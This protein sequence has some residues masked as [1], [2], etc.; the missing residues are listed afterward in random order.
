M[1]YRATV[2]SPRPTYGLGTMPG[3]TDP[4]SLYSTSY[5]RSGS[6]SRKYDSSSYLSSSSRPSSISRPLPPG[7]GPL[8]TSGRRF[9]TDSRRTS[10]SSL[11][12]GPLKADHGYTP[13]IGTLPRKYTNSVYAGS[14]TTSDI[15]SRSVRSRSVANFD[16]VTNDVSNLKLNDYDGHSI[17]ASPRTIDSD[18]NILGNRESRRE[19]HENSLDW[20]SGSR[21]SRYSNSSLNNDDKD[22]QNHVTSQNRERDSE[23]KRKDSL[24]DAHPTKSLSRQSSNSSISTVSC[25]FHKVIL[26]VKI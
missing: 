4:T 24:N 23:N 11:R 25:C 15:S 2:Y 10:T 14:S 12:N 1:S 26:K 20:R 13:S 7:P 17:K 8:D 21:V 3:R 16:R 9:S 22:I 19:K 18:D 5:R 6:A